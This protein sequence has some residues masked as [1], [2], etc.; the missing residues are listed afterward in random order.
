MEVRTFWDQL[1][2]LPSRNGCRL[3]DPPRPAVVLLFSPRCHACLLAALPNLVSLCEELQGA[4]ACAAVQVHASDPASERLLPASWS[5][6]KAPFPILLDP[7]GQIWRAE[8]G[9]PLW[10]VVDETGQVRHRIPGSGPA[11]MARLS[12]A[13]EELIGQLVRF[14][15]MG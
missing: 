6:D 14:R 7:A 13:I 11:A 1:A 5:L 4:I 15:G 2:S 10:L 12:Y 3:P 9:V 8:E